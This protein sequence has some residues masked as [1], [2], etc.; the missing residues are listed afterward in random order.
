MALT[1][2]LWHPPGKKTAFV[3]VN[4][5]DDLPK[6]TRVFL[7]SR[8]GHI[9]V[10]FQGE[11]GVHT[12]AS[13][14][15]AIAELVGEGP[16]TWSAICAAASL[17]EPPPGPRTRVQRGV[18]ILAFPPSQAEFEHLDADMKSNPIPEPTHLLVDHREPPALVELLRGV[19]NLVVDVQQLEVADYV[20]D[21]VL[22]IE[23][24]EA[25]IDL[26]NSVEDGRLFRQAAALTQNFA[27][28]VILIEG[29]P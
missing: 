23:R 13:V 5:L 22:A 8:S 26:I 16:L 27:H 10:T 7:Q 4:G 19:R 1:L 24:K 21:G 17:S 2:R 20:V 15:S 3:Y 18:R 25:R 11:S 29:D 9:S 28:A 14:L 12:Q 6:S